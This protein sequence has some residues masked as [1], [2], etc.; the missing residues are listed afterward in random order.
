MR[1]RYRIKRL[2]KICTTLM[3]KIQHNKDHPIRQCFQ[4]RTNLPK[5]LRKAPPLIPYNKSF[6]GKE[7]ENCSEY[8]LLKYKAFTNYGF[9]N[10]CPA[11]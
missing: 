9:I 10:V 2:N 3:K 8:C 11:S 5:S 4:E 7:R 1:K 6:K